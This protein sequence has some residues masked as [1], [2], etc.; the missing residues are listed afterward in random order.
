LARQGL[1]KSAF[2]L[3]AIV[4]DP[5]VRSL[6]LAVAQKCNLGCSYCY[7][8][9][10]SFGGA[11]K[12]MGWPVAEAAILRLFEQA[13]PGERVNIAFLGG[14]PLTNRALVRQATE[15]ATRLSAE[16][17]V[18]VGFAITTNGTLLTPE[19]G[20]FFE[21]YGFSLTVS[22]DG[23][24]AVHDQLRPYKGGRGSYGALISRIEPL[25]AKRKRMSIAARVTVTPRNLGIRETLDQL[26]ALGFDS[27]G[28]APM[29]SAPS[30]RDE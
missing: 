3:D 28:F 8:Q 29:L 26:I 22:I 18:P 7:A 27:V 2:M 10:G 20:D 12:A 24:G 1:S 11:E 13:R 19:D 23:I 17:S 9:G 15:L 21:R 6:S 5:P 16:R 30:G 14:E 4:A 25:L